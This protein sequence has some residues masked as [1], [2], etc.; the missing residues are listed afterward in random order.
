MVAN[1]ERATQ[2]LL[3]DAYDPRH[4][5]HDAMVNFECNTGLDI[6]LLP[7]F[8]VLIFVPNGPETAVEQPTPPTV[9]ALP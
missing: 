6:A 2:Q 3:I 8:E 7:G 5:D 9:L 4:P 1:E